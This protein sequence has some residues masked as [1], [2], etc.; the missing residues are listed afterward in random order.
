MDILMKD[1]NESMVSEG[2]VEPTVATMIDKEGDI[3]ASGDIDPAAQDTFNIFEEN[4][5]LKPIARQILDEKEGIIRTGDGD[6]AVYVTF[7]T[8]ES[9]GWKLCIISPVQTVIKPANDIRRSIDS[10]TESVVSSVL[11]VVLVVIQIVLILTAL[12]LIIVT[13]FVGRISRRI[14]DPLRQLE[15]DVRKISGGN[16]E[17]RTSVNTDDEIGS[18]AQTFPVAYTFSV[19]NPLVELPKIPPAYPA[20][21]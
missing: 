12:I 13:L 19:S 5:F 14:S 2:I 18:L 9:T 15:E 21:A 8:V 11:R 20:V 3:V 16:L 4:S 17:N 1:L 7:A 6:D 10:N